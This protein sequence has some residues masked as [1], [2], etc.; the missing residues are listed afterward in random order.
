KMTREMWDEVMHVN[1]DSLFIVT[2]RFLPAMVAAGWGRLINI[3]SVVAE[4]GNFGQ[5]NYAASKGACIAFMKSLAR[6][7]ARKGVTANCVAP[8]FI[9][10]DM[11]KPIPAAGIDQVK[12]LT[13]VGRLGQPEDVA[14]AV[15][16]LASPRAGFITGH[17]LSV[18]G[19]MHM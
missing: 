6:E 10:T 13:P 2:Q 9:D 14:H 11:L 7:V 8:G 4:M 15:T 1:V 17:V 19:G 12:A 3:S 5:A 16:F 18:N